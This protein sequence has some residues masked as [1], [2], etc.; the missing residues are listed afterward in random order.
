AVV[1]IDGRGERRA[2]DARLPCAAPRAD[3][4][5]ARLGRRRVARRG[6]AVRGGRDGPR[7]GG[8]SS[9]AG[10]ALDRQ[11][12][13]RGGPRALWLPVR[14][15]APDRRAAHPIGWVGG[16]IGGK[17]KE[18]DL[19]DRAPMTFD[20]RPLRRR[21]RGASVMVTGAGGSIG[22]QL[23]DQLLKLEIGG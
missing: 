7:R 13:R 10:G 2:D 16:V 14:G 6:A 18:E 22:G 8:G 17:V 19:L 11:R 23:I 21:F 4:D 12:G 15:L 3:R 5:S 9:A 1:R 20:E